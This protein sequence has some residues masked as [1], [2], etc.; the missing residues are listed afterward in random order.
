MTDSRS[1]P[2]FARHIAAGRPRRSTWCGTTRSP[3]WG[4][5]SA[6]ATA[7]SFILRLPS[8]R[9]GALGHARVGRADESARGPQGSTPDAAD[10][11]GHGRRPEIPLPPDDGVRRG[12]PR[13]PCAPLEV[14]D[15]GHET[16]GHPRRHPACPEARGRERG[17]DGFASLAH[18]PRNANRAMPVLSVMMRMPEMWGNRQHNSNPCRDTLRY[19]MP[20]KERYLSNGEMARLNAVLA[21]DEFWCPHVVA[22]VRLLMPTGCP[23]GEVVALEWSWIKGR[24]VHLPDFKSRPGR[25]RATWTTSPSIGS[26]VA[27]RRACPACGFTTW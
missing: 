26:A 15:A 5:P 23:F 17:H 4:C 13:T 6:R 16:V 3:G 1:R 9:Q 10:A 18:R 19:R 8:S 24:R 14:G 7:R 22:I 11:A 20:P 2:S 25:P 21:R 12:V 27:T